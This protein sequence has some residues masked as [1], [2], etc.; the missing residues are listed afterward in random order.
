MNAAFLQ[1]DNVSVT[2]SG[3]WLERLTGP[4]VPP[5]LHPGLPVLR[6]RR[7]LRVYKL[8][9]QSEVCGTLIGQLC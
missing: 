9:A 8:E 1:H 7:G 3:F 2:P 5:L 4:R 6:P